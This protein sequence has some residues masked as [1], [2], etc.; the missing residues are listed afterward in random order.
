MIRQG[1]FRI[2]WS[3]VGKHQWWC[4]CVAL[5]GSVIFILG[6]RFFGAE[7][8]RWNVNRE[9]VYYY[10]LLL[11]ATPLLV[12]LTRRRIG[13][14]RLSQTLLIVFVFVAVVAFVWHL[15]IFQEYLSAPQINDIP[16]RTLVAISDFLSGKNPY[17]LSADLRS[18]LESGALYWEGYVYMPMMIFLYMPFG[19]IW[20]AQ[21][22]LATNLLLDLLVVILLCFI[23]RR[24]RSWATGFL[25]AFL[26]LTVLLIPYELYRTGSTD[27]A[28]VVPLL[29]ALLLFGRKPG[30]VGF[31]VGL[32]MATKL[33]PG[34]LFALGLFSRSRWRS[35][36]TGIIVGFAPFFAF[37]VASFSDVLTGTVA[38]NFVRPA[39]PTS[40]QHGLLMEFGVGARF[41]FVWVLLNVGVYVWLRQ[42]GVVLRLGL[43]IVLMLGL[44]LSSPVNHCN[45]Q[46]WWL[47]FYALLVALAVFGSSPH[48]VEVKERVV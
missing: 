8:C 25:A 38:F 17:R 6:G 43:V 22:V 29:A 33:F 4:W 45:Y 27:L 48:E 37:L 46:L 31:F 30:W 40:W 21:G 19:V 12:R 7:I 28:A 9:V 18:V 5:V 11:V 26:Y 23:G 2:A 36:V 20:H 34:I 32:S 1:F 42:P 14:L 15:T 39:D 35:Y 47:P 13:S 41:V 16:G 24:I 3:F 10:I 44:L